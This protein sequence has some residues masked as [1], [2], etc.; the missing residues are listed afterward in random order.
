M[1]EDAKD[2]C[3]AVS[4]LMHLRLAAVLRSEVVEAIARPS[5]AHHP[6]LSARSETRVH[7]YRTARAEAP[8]HTRGNQSLWRLNKELEC[9]REPGRRR[10]VKWAVGRVTRAAG[11]CLRVGRGQG[12]RDQARMAIGRGC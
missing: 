6:P 7:R 4:R 2:T 11:R 5:T 8:S 1:S 3:N 10:C 9:H 12:A